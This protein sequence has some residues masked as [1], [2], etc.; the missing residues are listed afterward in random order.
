M[1]TFG[2]IIL[3]SGI[4]TTINLNDVVDI[5]LSKLMKR[6]ITVFTLR[7]LVRHILSAAVHSELSLL[8]TTFTVNRQ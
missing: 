3:K 6:V 5:L 2:H 4:H 7:F 1:N 8:S